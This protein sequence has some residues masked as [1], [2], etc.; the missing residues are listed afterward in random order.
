LCSGQATPERL[1]LNVVRAR[2]L[3]V[4]LDDRHPLAIPRLELSI[5][6][7]RDLLER[8]PELVAEHVQLRLRALAEVAAVRFVERYP[9]I[10]DTSHA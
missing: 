7:D 2:T 6:V 8:E 4:D 9:R 5:A 1:R 10:R 3:A